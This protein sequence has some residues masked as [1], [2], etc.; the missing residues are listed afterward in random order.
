MVRSRGSRIVNAQL[1][2]VVRAATT[3]AAAG[4]VTVTGPVV[5]SDG[6]V[7]ASTDLGVP[8][9]GATD[10]G[11]ARATDL[12]VAP[13]MYRG[14]RLLDFVVLAVIAVP[15]L[16]VTLACAIAIWCED[17]RPVLIRQR[18][19]GSGGQPFTLLKLRTMTRD[20]EPDA[21]VP[22][23]SRITRVG[24]VLRRFSIDELPQFVNVARGEMSLVG[25]RP[26]FDHRTQ[27]Y[28]A[29]QRQ[30]LAALPGLTGLA[31]TSGRNQLGW[32][33]RT[34]LDLHYV[35]TQNLWLDLRILAR[36]PWVV[37]TGEGVSGHPGD[38]PADPTAPPSDPPPGHRAGRKPAGHAAR[39]LGWTAAVVVVALVA[40]AGW[41][42]VRGLQARDHLVAATQLV[43]QLEQQMARGDVTAGQGTVARLRQETRAA[44][45]A[46]HGTS[47]R[48]G[49]VAPVVGDDLAALATVTGALDELVARGAA[50][51]AAMSGLGPAALAPHGGRMDLAQLQRIAPALAEASAAT[52][53]AS[54]RIAAIRAGELAPPLRSAVTELRDRLAR[55]AA[56]TATVARAATIL[57][58]MLGAHGP[59]TYLVLFQN[60]AE[61]RATGG[62]P[63]AFAVVRADHGAITLVGQGSASA[64]LQVFDQPVLPLNPAQRSLYTDRLGT[65]PADITFTPDFPTAAALAREMYRR[66]T[67]Q[68]VDGVLATDPVAL[69]YLLAATGPVRMP[70]GEVLA[71]GT[72]VRQLLS[73]AYARYATSVEQDQYFAG[74]ARVMFDVVAQGLGDPRAV[75]AALGRAADERRLLVWSAHP[76][77]QRTIDGTAVSGM[78]PRHDADQPTVGVFLNDGTGAKLG[79]YLSFAADLRPSGCLAEGRQE[80]KLRL[81]IRSTAPSSG[82]SPSVLGMGLAG[83][84][85]TIRTNVL[86]F[87][88]VAG[89]V[90]SASVDGVPS[91]FGTGQE[92]GRAVGVLTVDVAPGST[93]TIQV[94]VLTAVQAPGA[95]PASALRLRT[96]PAA[97]PWH[98]NIG[99]PYN[100]VP[101]R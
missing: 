33:D 27:R 46:T 41:L 54:G 72:V 30:R 50:A 28:D 10:L 24:R 58:P 60:L 95:R 25:P 98:T 13:R 77:E 11:A 59:R 87:S 62:M 44:R 81:T 97:T 73:D 64:V 84:P 7:A 1:R 75:L 69:S 48:A 26:N 42:T 52:A 100:C 29:R 14:K 92:S 79:Y 36:S 3:R 78:L 9:L 101:V 15:A 32:D 35:H 16:L 61:L 63:G 91:G 93:R 4:P 53:Q 66:R 67:G 51:L 23:E 68:T 94:T 88:P 83:V 31:Q 19:T 74:V 34:E 47:W 8:D 55:V 22:D 12:G 71:A 96:T 6:R 49:R 37:L 56:T 57:P 65:F 76:D 89:A 90:R 39:R 40:G 17:G 99:F 20:A 70:G 86:V 43:R 80:L 21:E 85:Y 18:R 2:A 5:T 45:A 38:R 82:L